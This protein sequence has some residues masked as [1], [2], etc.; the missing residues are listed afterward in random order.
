MVSAKNG[1][2]L[3]VGPMS[4]LGRELL[5]FANARASALTIEKPGVKITLARQGGAWKMISPVA[6][7]AEDAHVQSILADLSNLRGR[8]VVGPAA[9][10]AKYGLDQA[11]LKV[12]VTEDAPASP[13]KPGPN[14]TFRSKTP[15]P[16]PLTFEKLPDSNR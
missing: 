1:E 10:V 11:S 4:F 3:S 8:R 2:D 9:D 15:E 13:P 5:K 16:T 7:D 6:G 14:S 12:V